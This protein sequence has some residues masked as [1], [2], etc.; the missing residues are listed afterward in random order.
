MVYYTKKQLINDKNENGINEFVQHRIENDIV[1][2]FTEQDTKTD[3]TDNKINVMFNLKYETTDKEKELQNRINFIVTKIM[4]VHRTL[5]IDKIK[6]KDKGK[7]SY[8]EKSN[9][10]TSSL[11]NDC[12]VIHDTKVMKKFKKEYLDDL[13]E[14]YKFLS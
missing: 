11:P 10:D 6:S 13:V 14:V 8:Y 9:G 1:N 12:F 3:P 5:F 4:A 2:K 7:V